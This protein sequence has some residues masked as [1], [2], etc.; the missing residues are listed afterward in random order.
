MRA[1]KYDLQWRS[2]NDEDSET[3]ATENSPEVIDVSNDVSPEGE[4]EFGFDSKHLK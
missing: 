2:V 4:G 3:C 1:S